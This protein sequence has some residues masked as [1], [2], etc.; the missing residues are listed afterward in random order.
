MCFWGSVGH[1][2]VIKVWHG[3]TH[4]L[5]GQHVGHTEAVGCLALDANFLFSGSED[6]TIRVWDSISKPPPNVSATPSR[7][8]RTFIKALE[9]HER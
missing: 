3:M 4:E 9:G 2:Q 6:C 7:S 8:A 1:C 5:V